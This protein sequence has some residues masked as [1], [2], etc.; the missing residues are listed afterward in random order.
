M[1]CLYNIM[2]TEIAYG[3]FV[4][5]MSYHSFAPA[6]GIIGSIILPQNF[7]IHRFRFC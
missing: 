6:V 3:T 5:D 7:F 4:P 2:T 1:Y